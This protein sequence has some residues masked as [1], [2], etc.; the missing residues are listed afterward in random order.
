M[1]EIENYEPFYDGMPVTVRFMNGEDV[2]CT[3][4]SPKDN[5]DFTVILHRPLQITALPS[6]TTKRNSSDG[7]LIRVRFSKWMPLSDEETYIV[8][9]SHVIALAPLSLTLVNSYMEWSGKL[10]DYQI[11]PTQLSSTTEQPTQNT[12]TADDA[13]DILTKFLHE[14][15]PKGKAN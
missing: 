11:R 7:T 9:D 15:K 4:Y 10:Y 3:A 6:E 2:I 12:P 13:T 8:Q 1:S 5:M 14:Y